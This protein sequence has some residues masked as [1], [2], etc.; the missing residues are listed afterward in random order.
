MD[1]E[2]RMAGL[3]YGGDSPAF[4]AIDGVPVLNSRGVWKPLCLAC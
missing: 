1:A 4:S 2:V 3:P